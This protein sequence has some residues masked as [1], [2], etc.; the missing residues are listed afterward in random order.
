MKKLRI[1]T[2]SLLLLSFF[3]P[4]LF[5]SMCSENSAQK[6]FE[7]LKDSLLKDSITKDSLFK[8]SLDKKGILLQYL[9]SIKY[10]KDSVKIKHVAF[11]SATIDSIKTFSHAFVHDSLDSSVD[12]KDRE[13][14]EN[15]ITKR[16]SRV[17]DFIFNP[18]GCLS[19]FQLVIL[20]LSI[21]YDTD[22]EF[23]TAHL[24]FFIFALNY[25]IILC[26]LIRQFFNPKLMKYFYLSFVSLAVILTYGLLVGTTQLLW[27][28]YVMLIIN[29]L[30][31]IV[32]YLSIRNQKAKTVTS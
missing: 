18:N 20:F 19:G 27:G 10:I 23:Q 13:I 2:K 14:K 1:L 30:D 11:E 5:F 9:D 6:R 21:P 16:L 8:V 3:L 7:F 22:Y 15:L 12:A 28:F 32:I 25:I 24:I 17:W 31:I 29:I 4:F 26:S